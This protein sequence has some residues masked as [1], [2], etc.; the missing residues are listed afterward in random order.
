MKT[1]ARVSLAVFV[2]IAVLVGSALSPVRC[3][4]QQVPADRESAYEVIRDVVYGHAGKRP[5]H[6]DLYRPKHPKAERLPVV[7]W[8]HG[9]GWRAGSKSSGKAILPRFVRTGRYVGAAVEYR[10]TTEATWPAQVHDCKAAIRWL[11]ANAARY[12]I[13][14][15]RIGVIGGSAGGHLAALL[16]T[17]GGVASLEGE[18]GFP[19]HSSR[20]QAVVD[21][22]GPTDLVSIDQQKLLP[23]VRQLLVDFLGGPVKEKRSQAQAASPA[24]YITRDDPPVLIVHGTQDS[25]VPFQQAE[26][27]HR[28]LKAGGVECYLY[29]IQGADHG[30]G[31]PHLFQECLRFFDKCLW[32]K[33]SRFEDRT[34]PKEKQ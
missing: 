33:P 13:D 5:L 1:P 12:G 15:R 3:P 20:V 17:S 31:G 9:G 22:C 34:I 25:I 27:F 24:N 10:L 26:L 29:R 7:V 18:C 28:K 30:I 16:G 19:G 6:L 14:P 2:W 11:R 23:P 21:F 32:G 4:A 8:L